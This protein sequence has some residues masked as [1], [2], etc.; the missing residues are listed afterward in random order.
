MRRMMAAQDH[1]ANNRLAVT[2]TVAARTFAGH[3]EVAAPRD[4]QIRI[5][6]TTAA[7]P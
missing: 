2:A 5:P 1:R 4:V 7:T 6:T 3:R